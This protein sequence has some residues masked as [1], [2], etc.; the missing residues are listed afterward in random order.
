MDPGIHG[1]SGRPEAR[2]SDASGG[3]LVK[4]GS[5]DG[6]KPSSD[7]TR[8]LSAVQAGDAGAPER[9]MGAVYDELRE[10]AGRQLAREQAG[11]TL[12]PT[13]LIH[14]AWLRLGGDDQPR[15]ENRGHFFSAA[16]E[17][18]R[19]ILVDSARRKGRLRRGG[20]RERVP[21]TSLDLAATTVPDQVLAVDEALDQLARH[22]PQGAELIKLRFF[23]GLNHVQA[24]KVLG[25]SERT[26]KRVWAY[27]RAWL[28]EELQRGR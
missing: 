6:E 9:L 24:A 20:D 22:D 17:A 16:A 7:I 21:L 3:L 23:V 12:Q 1:R 13:A 10:L 2:S 4:P 18:M 19:R 15:W 28:H 11:Q 26:A 14:E 8:L 27:A 25:L 5:G